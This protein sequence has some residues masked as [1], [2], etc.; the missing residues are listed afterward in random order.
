MRYH[1]RTNQPLN[2]SPSPPL[3]YQPTLPPTSSPACPVTNIHVSATSTRVTYTRCARSFVCTDNSC[4]FT[5]FKEMVLSSS[6]SDNTTTTSHKS[7]S[8]SHKKDSSGSN[9]AKHYSV[10]DLDD[11]VPPVIAPPR[12]KGGGGGG[13]KEKSFSIGKQN[14]IKKALQKF[15]F[16]PSKTAVSQQSDSSFTSFDDSSTSTLSRTGRKGSASSS[17]SSPA[18]ALTPSL[19]HSHS[20]PDL[21][22]CC[23]EGRS[24]YP[25]YVI[26]VYKADQSFKYLPLHRVR[27]LV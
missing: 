2:R 8:S 22:L 15:S 1:A 5:A 18:T 11:C 24:E 7:S 20:N 16:L 3:T 21:T 14:K 27:R 19:G 4:C 12:D 13:G 10:S 17:G 9:R 26:K 23:D 25:E 6:S